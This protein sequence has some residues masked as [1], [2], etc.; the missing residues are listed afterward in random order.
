MNSLEPGQRRTSIRLDTVL[1]MLSVFCLT[2]PEIAK[3]IPRVFL[4][5]YNAFHFK[6]GTGWTFY[7]Y[8]V[9][10]S[11]GSVNKSLIWQALPVYRPH[12]LP[13]PKSERATSPIYPYP[14]RLSMYYPLSAYRVMWPRV[15]GMVLFILGVF[16]RS[17]SG[18][19]L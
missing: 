11:R 14:D 1:F 12:G 18:R 17:S 7:Y 13:R 16:I 3:S 15:V 10:R 6:N 9:N 4:W 5:I 2:V 19:R 8:I